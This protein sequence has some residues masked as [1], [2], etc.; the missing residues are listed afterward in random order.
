MRV[1][2]D[3]ISGDEIASDSFPISEKGCVYII[4][5]KMVVKEAGDYGISSNA[6]EDAEGATGES[7]A[8]TKEKVIDVVDAHRLVQTPFDK[9]SWMVYIKGYM[10]RIREHI[11]KTKPG[12]EAAF[13]QEAT[14]FVKSILAKFDDYTFYAGESCNPD[15]MYSILFWSEDGLTPSF[16]VFKDGVTEE[17][18]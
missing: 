16:Y 17:K 15:A 14:E 18:Y 1:F 3:V 6:D 9:K 2:K 11:K 13:V 8:S 12:R 5:G 10:G 7:L 4:K